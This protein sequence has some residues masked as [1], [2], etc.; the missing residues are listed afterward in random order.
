M[1]GG[2]RSIG[3]LLVLIAVH[4]G[5]PAGPL[6]AAGPY[7]VG[8]S[9]IDKPGDCTVESWASFAR[10]GDFIGIVAPACVVQLWQPVE[11][12]SEIKRDE[13]DGDWTSA[14]KI[15]GKINLV[16]LAHH[17]VGVGLSSNVNFNLTTGHAS[18][19]TI[20][21][22]VS[23]QLAEHL[24]LNLKL[25][26]QWDLLRDRSFDTWGAN[27]EVTLTPQWKFLAEVFGSDGKRPGAQA[28]LRY[29]PQK[30][31][32]L[33]FVYGYNLADEHADWFTVGVNLRF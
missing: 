29:T 15:K 18:T 10:N 23:F 31:V 1:L 20:F 8:S 28:G 21:P 11:L 2:S 26:M 22:T 3:C 27:V 16:S 14:L 13:T 30:N 32:D 4:A 24:R 5:V 9:E 6:L 7:S 19:A 33:E 25:G 17:P 12:G